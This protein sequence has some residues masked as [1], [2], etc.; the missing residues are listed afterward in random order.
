[1]DDQLL[2]VRQLCLSQAAGF[3]AAVDRLGCQDWPHIAFHLSLLALEEV[4]K[5][6]MLGAKATRTP[7]DDSWI[8]GQL[9]DH[10]R[11]LQWA[12]WSPFDRIDPADFEAARQFANRAHTMR[13]TSLYVDAGGDLSVPPSEQV[14]RDDAEQLLSLARS[15]LAYER[16]AIDIRPEPDDL[17]RW[18][19]DTAADPDKSRLLL[20]PSAEGRLAQAGRAAIVR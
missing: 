19:L 17:T 5:A 15:R 18:F 8:D 14:G 2:R 6:S 3:L 16:S 1:M 9:N 11:K 10:R 13:L 7:T 12:L 20:Y 4:G